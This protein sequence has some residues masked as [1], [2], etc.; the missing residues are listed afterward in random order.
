MRYRRRFKN[1]TPEQTALQ[2]YADRA[3]F[4]LDILTS[5]LGEAL[6]RRQ[7]DTEYDLKFIREIVEDID[8]ALKLVARTQADLEASYSK[9][10]KA[11]PGRAGKVQRAATRA[12]EAKKK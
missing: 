12:A 5:G 7:I 8:K 10:S 9:R 2:A 6:R 3:S 11:V 4:R 1:P